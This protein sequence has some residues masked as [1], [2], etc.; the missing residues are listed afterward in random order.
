MFLSFFK[1]IF[2]KNT[3]QKVSSSKTIGEMQN[4]PLSEWGAFGDNDI[5]EGLEFY[6]T[7]QLRTPLEILKHHGE[8]FS[9]RG[10]PPK[11]IKEDWQGIWLAKTKIE[12]KLKKESL[13]ASD[14]GSVNDTLYIKYLIPFREIVESNENIDTKIRLLENKA[15]ENDTFKSFWEKHKQMDRDFPHSFF[16][17]QLTA[18]EGIGNKT[19]KILY[20]S[21]FKSIDVIKNATDE[22]LLNVKGVGKNL[23]EKI[24]L[25]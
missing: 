23:V 10:V 8:V 25:A 20:E 9:G 6:A 1:N 13:S 22:E 21:G 12:Y 2:L 16:Y 11:Y 24:R 17:K 7:L 3:Q 5:M 15:K 18:I 14:I 4:Q 19:A